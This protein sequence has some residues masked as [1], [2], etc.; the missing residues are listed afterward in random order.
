MDGIRA[1]LWLAVSAIAGEA[2]MAAAALRIPARISARAPSIRRA[3]DLPAFAAIP[4]E[5]R[6]ELLILAATPF[7]GL[8]LPLDRTPAVRLSGL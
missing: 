2:E 5:S 1:T 4:A 6:D 8:S 3:R 7:M